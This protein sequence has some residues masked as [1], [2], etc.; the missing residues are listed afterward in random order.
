LKER[1]KRERKIYRKRLKRKGIGKEIKM[2]RD[3]TKKK[4]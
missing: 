1:R 3:E 2:G 4:K